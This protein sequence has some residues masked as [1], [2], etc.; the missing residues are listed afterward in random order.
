MHFKLLLSCP[1]ESSQEQ[2]CMV[3]KSSY[4]HSFLVWCV[5]SGSGWTRHAGE[6]YSVPVCPYSHF[7]L[8]GDT[9]VL[10]WDLGLGPQDRKSLGR[11]FNSVPFSKTSEWNLSL[12]WGCGHISMLLYDKM[13]CKLAACWQERWSNLPYINSLASC[14]TFTLGEDYKCG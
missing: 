13:V 1:L 10:L 14:L 6:G 7:S 3:P 9:Y 12:I 5:Q 2:W 8:M 11:I 4:T